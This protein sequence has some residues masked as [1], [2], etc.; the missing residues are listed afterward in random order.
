MLA[1][2]RKEQF[3][4]W[5][6]FAND[7]RRMPLYEWERES[8]WEGESSKDTTWDRQKCE[9]EMEIWL[10]WFAQF[11]HIVRLLKVCEFLLLRV[12]CNQT[13]LQMCCSFCA[14]CCYAN[15]HWTPNPFS[16]IVSHFCYHSS[17]VFNTIIFF[18]DFFS[19][20]QLP[21]KLCDKCSVVCFTILFINVYSFVAC[22][23]FTFLFLT[24]FVYLSF[25]FPHYLLLQPK[26][27][28]LYNWTLIF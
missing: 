3:V 20:S 1:T 17:V 5:M 24:K 16:R 6:G 12:V 11:S 19:L 28:F 4:A 18:N 23:F 27:V 9:W 21:G 10:I 14:L 15:N 25:P 22:N 26:R 2:W 7:G 8:R 13:S